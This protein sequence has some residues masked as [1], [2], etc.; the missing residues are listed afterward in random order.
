[1][2]YD[3][4][5]CKEAVSKLIK[6]NGGSPHW[7][8]GPD[9]PDYFVEIDNVKYA[10]E[11]TSI[12]G[13]TE[14]ENK[15]YTWTQL[16]N[17]LLDFGQEICDQIE[18]KVTVKG[19]YFLSLPP[20]P[21]LKDQK[22]KILKCALNFFNLN[23][24]NTGVTSKNTIFK[25]KNKEV[26]IWKVK[27][28]GSAITPMSLPGGALITRREEQLSGLLK[29]AIESKI[30]KLKGFNYPKILVILDR[31]GFERSK[32]EWKDNISESSTNFFKSIIRVQ[33]NN[34]QYITGEIL[35]S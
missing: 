12:H 31:Y 19:S 10:V 2:R 32:D 35:N 4:E 17:E 28:T 23:S 18:L 26:E 13:F 11:V 1:M 20:L 7:E 29:V 22:S 9:P 3:E 25:I 16:S 21:S 34:A 6:E 15:R 24:L 5:L 14:L 27:D 8:E 30:Q 33:N